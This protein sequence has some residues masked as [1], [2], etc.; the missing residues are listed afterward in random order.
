MQAPGVWRNSGVNRESAADV[1]REKGD[2][3]FSFV[4]AKEERVCHTAGVFGLE[5]RGFCAFRSIMTCGQVATAHLRRCLWCRV[6]LEGV[7]ILLQ[8][9]FGFLSI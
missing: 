2:A 9:N 7:A 4:D 5:R 8:D 6:D 1:A 3:R